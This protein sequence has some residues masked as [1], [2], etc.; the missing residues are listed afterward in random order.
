MLRLSKLTDYSTVIMFYMARQ[1]QRVCSAAEAAAA[2][3]LPAAT[4]SKLMK[5]LVRG[6]LLLSRRG[7][8]GGY[9][10]ARPP[11]SI[12]LAQV[13]EAL[14]GSFGVT[15]CSS[16]NGACPQE[17]ACPARL[18]WLQ[19]NSLIRRTLAGTSLADMTAV[20]PTL[21]GDTGIPV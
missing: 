7:A 19:V 8:A 13:I 14:D 21:P 18:P 9:V 5:A 16:G 12:S 6:G 4:A 1:P 17:A 2:L 20:P 15:E 11:E 3:G 10:L